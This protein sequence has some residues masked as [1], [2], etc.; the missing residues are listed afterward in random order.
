MRLL[1]FACLL[2]LTLTI[3]AQTR[4]FRWDDELCRYSGTYD[5]KRFTAVQLKNTFDLAETAGLIPLSTDST[6]FKY[7]DIAKLDV[8][9]LDREYAQRLSE[10]KG[11]D[12]V[13]VPYWQKFRERKIRELHEFYRLERVTML[14]YRDPKELLAYTRAP[15]CTTKYAKPL[16]SGGSDL[17]AAWKALNEEARKRN[18]D[19]ERVRRTYEERLRSP[20]RLQYAFIDIITFGWSN[21]ANATIPYVRGD[22]TPS[23]EFRK[24][25]KRTRTLH[26]DEP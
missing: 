8:D 25:F 14:G 6:A 23:K 7:S 20:D 3:T 9:A 5:S 2:F 17:L 24:L 13:P 26:C 1:T 22:Q 12:I 21:C 15:A 18:A 10:L 11:L 16:I 4:T 19:P